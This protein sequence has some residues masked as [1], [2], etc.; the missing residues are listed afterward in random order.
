MLDDTLATL[1]PILAIW[2]FPANQFQ[3]VKASRETQNQLKTI[4]ATVHLLLSQSQHHNSDYRKIWWAP[5]ISTLEYAF[6][7]NMVDKR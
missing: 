1:G 6:H 2:H 5:P 4:T 7:H 3:P